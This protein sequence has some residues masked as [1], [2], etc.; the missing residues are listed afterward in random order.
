M[1]YT[2]HTSHTEAMARVITERAAGHR[3]YL[4]TLRKGCYEVRVW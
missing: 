1:T 4:L 3:A 2:H